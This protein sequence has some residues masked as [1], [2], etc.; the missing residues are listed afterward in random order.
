[1]C[2]CS[3]TGT[4]FSPCYSSG[5]VWGVCGRTKLK[6]K[7]ICARQV[8]QLRL[9]GLLRIFSVHSS[10]PEPSCVRVCVSAH[11]HVCFFLIHFPSV[12]CEVVLSEIQPALFIR[13][14]RSHGC[15]AQIHPCHETGRERKIAT[16]AIWTFV[17]FS[18]LR[19]ILDS[20]VRPQ[21]LQFSSIHE[22]VSKLRRVKGKRRH[23]QTY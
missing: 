20:N 18:S 9:H 5:D 6:N 11:L 13:V 21:N 16:R 2:K 19:W 1:M 10:V 3:L 23:T 12:T 8:E 7:H 14:M 15:K 17:H 22:T 4:S